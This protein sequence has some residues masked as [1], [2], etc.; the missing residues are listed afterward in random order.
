MDDGIRHP[1]DSDK[2]DLDLIKD[3]TANS[4]SRLGVKWL[5]NV[6]NHGMVIINDYEALGHA[7]R[8]NIAKNGV[9]VERLIE[10]PYW[11]EGG[12]AMT[13]IYYILESRRL[14]RGLNKLVKTGRMLNREYQLIHALQM[15]IDVETPFMTYYHD[16]IDCDKKRK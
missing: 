7:P 5:E 12:W 8:P 14:F 10:K 6:K 2:N 13:G 1:V 4:T 16:W 15:M 9:Q 11:D 3:I